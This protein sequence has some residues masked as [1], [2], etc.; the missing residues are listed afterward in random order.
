MKRSISNTLTGSNTPIPK[1]SKYSNFSTKDPNYIL[2]KIHLA[3]DSAFDSHNDMPNELVKVFSSRYQKSDEKLTTI[4]ELSEEIE[5]HKIDKDSE[6]L[7]ELM[8]LRKKKVSEILETIKIK[9]TPPELA[10]ELMFILEI[11]V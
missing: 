3:E 8:T 1:K 5:E 11:F 7:I 10:D 2:K 4:F 9:H 6:T